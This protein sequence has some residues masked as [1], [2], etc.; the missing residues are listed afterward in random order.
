MPNRAR[1]YA[2]IGDNRRCHIFGRAKVGSF[3]VTFDDTGEVVVLPASAIKRVC[4]TPGCPNPPKVTKSG[5]VAPSCPACAKANYAARVEGAR[6]TI[7]H[8]SGERRQEPAMRVD[9][10]GVVREELHISRW[11][12]GGKTLWDRGDI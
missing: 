5:I 8:Y 4:E 1:A 7:T 12:H 9:G 3:R 2:T 10:T 6:R 11:S